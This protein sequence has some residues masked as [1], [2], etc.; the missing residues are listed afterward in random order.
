MLGFDGEYSAVQVKEKFWGFLAK[1][2]KKSAVKYIIEK[3]IFLNFVNLSTTF[4]P[5][6]SEETKFYW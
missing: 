3:P 1:N 2:G 4:C 5:G 6:L